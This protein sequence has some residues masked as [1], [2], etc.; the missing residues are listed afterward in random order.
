MQAETGSFWSKLEPKRA[1]H[2]SSRCDLFS[3][4]V[5]LEARSYKNICG[6]DKLEFTFLDRLL[7]EA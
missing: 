6:Y 3:L 1:T 4:A 5:K 2:S 7:N